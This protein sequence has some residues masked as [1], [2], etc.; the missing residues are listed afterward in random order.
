MSGLITLYKN[1]ALT[2]ELSD[3][4]WVQSMLLPTTTLPGTGS[5]TTSGVAG[6]ALNEGTTTMLDVYIQPVAGGGLN[7]TSFSNNIQI[8]PDHLGTPG[9]YGS[10]GSNVLVY[11]G[12]FA[13][14]VA[15]PGFN[16]SSPLISNPSTAPTL[17]AIGTTTLAASGST[18]TF[19]A[20]T[21]TVAYSYTNA[22]GETLVSSSS[23]IALSAGQ[24]I[25]VNQI[26]LGTD[27]TG[28]VYYVS[29]IANRTEI[30]KSGTGTGGTATLTGVTG[31]LR[32]WARQVV[33]YNDPTGVYKAQLTVSAIDIG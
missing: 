6:Y 22:G 29:P 14:S 9:T 4:S 32:F 8:A 3:G 5:T 24:G 7:G 27:A 20:G 12:E 10:S 13:P 25:R 31:F 2:Q 23:T 15:E 18:S 19:A 28:I 30:Y 33:D 11:S 17:A 1:A 21:Y 16:T 26:S